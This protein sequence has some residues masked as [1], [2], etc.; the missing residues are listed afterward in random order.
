MGLDLYAKVEPYLDFEEQVGELHRE[1]L[2][3]VFENE[4][5]NIIDIGCG[6]GA[7]MMHLSANGVNNYGIDLSAK[8]IQ[9]CHEFGLKAEHKALNEVTQT[10]SCATAIF[11]VINYIPQNAVERFFKDTAKVLEK[12]GYFFFDVNS[13]HG[14]ED[15]A[16][17]SLNINLDDKFIGIDAY[18]E[19]QELNTE[20]TLFTQNSDGTYTKE[21]G[22][23]TQYYYPVKTLR[24]YLHNAG[25]KV[26][27]VLNFHLHSNEDADKYIFICKKL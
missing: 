26:Q 19:E 24:N 25:F 23:I 1:F 14:F 15:V 22:A 10:F 5:D 7:F 3:L 8:Q 9:V 21:Q 17:G 6:Q 16:Q 27:E 13:L 20:I 18:F 11:D 12:E 4:C 2:R